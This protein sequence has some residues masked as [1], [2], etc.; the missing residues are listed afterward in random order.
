MRA[1][2][3]YSIEISVINISIRFSLASPVVPVIEELG[4][5]IFQKDF[6]ISFIS[7][8]R[9]S[10]IKDDSPIGNNLIRSV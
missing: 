1:M 4:M 3:D 8:Y 9:P 7:P 10:N 6:T 5:Y 2:R